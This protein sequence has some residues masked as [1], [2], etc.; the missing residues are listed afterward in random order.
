MSYELWVW[1]KVRVWI[2]VVS[3]VLR[4]IYHTHARTPTHNP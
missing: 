4:G 2:S 1:A 3:N